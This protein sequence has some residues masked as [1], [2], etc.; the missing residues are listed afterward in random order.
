M[1]CEQ[2]C[3][4]AASVSHLFVVGNLAHGVD[5]VKIADGYLAQLAATMNITL[6]PGCDDLTTAVLPQQP[7]HRCLF[8]RASKFPSFKSETNPLYCT[9]Q[10]QLYEK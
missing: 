7:T 6:V 4:N 10:D 9:I 8:P 5:G 2:D 3:K 1:H